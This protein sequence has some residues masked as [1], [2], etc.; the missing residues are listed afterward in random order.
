MDKTFVSQNLILF[1]NTTGKSLV[2]HRK[3][4]VSKTPKNFRKWSRSFT[5]KQLNLEG[6][7]P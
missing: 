1:S 6:L 5:E 2:V 7:G 4:D 3:T